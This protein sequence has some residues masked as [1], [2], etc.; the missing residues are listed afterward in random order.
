MSKELSRTGVQVDEVTDRQTAMEMLYHYYNHVEPVLDEFDS[1]T[2]PD[3]G[4]TGV[5]Q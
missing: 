5:G 3:T 2:V 4:L 1:E